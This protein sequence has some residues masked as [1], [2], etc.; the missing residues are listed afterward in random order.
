[1]SCHAEDVPAAQ[2]TPM[3]ADLARRNIEEGAA[4]LRAA[5]RAGVKIALGS[6]VSLGTGAEI[7]LMI[8]HGS[9]PVKR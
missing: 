7:Q 5:R 4:T 8:R 1:V 9:P 2:M 6:D 3:L